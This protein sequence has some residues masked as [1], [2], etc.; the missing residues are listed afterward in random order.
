MNGD[1]QGALYT[2]IRQTL[3]EM[4]DCGGR[5]GDFD[6]Y[7]HPGSYR[8]RLHSKSVGQAILYTQLSK[9]L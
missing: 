7:D 8:R 5:D 4:V 3:R 9:C 1:E 6:L 2:A